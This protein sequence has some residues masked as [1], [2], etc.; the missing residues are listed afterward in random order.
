[1]T[2]PTAS[3]PSIVHAPPS[4]RS[5]RGPDRSMHPPSWRAVQRIG[6]RVSPCG[7]TRPFRNWLAGIALLWSVLWVQLAI[8]HGTLGRAVALSLFATACILT[9]L[10]GM[11]S[12][13]ER[14]GRVLPNLTQLSESRGARVRS[15]GRG[16]GPRQ[17]SPMPPPGIVASAA[18]ATG[19]LGLISWIPFSPL[20]GLLIIGTIL[21]ANPLALMFVAAITGVIAAGGFLLM[22][23]LI[24]LGRLFAL[25]IMR[26][27]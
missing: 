5:R 8:V 9:I 7:A 24:G 1:M 25:W 21:D 20:L 17:R 4:T 11:R 12:Y 18:A 13:V 22:V 10:Y 27:H 15:S 3:H 6:L 26:E 23:L 14:S 2:S 19:L 16:T